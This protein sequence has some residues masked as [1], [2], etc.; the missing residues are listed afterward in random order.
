LTILRKK[1]KDRNFREILVLTRFL[2]NTELISLFKKEGVDD[3]SVGNLLNGLSANIEVEFREKGKNVFEFHEP[4]DKFYIILIGKVSVVK[5]IFKEQLMDAFSYYKYLIKLKADS[6][7]YLL[8]ATIAGN[9]QV[10]PVKVDELDMIEEVIFKFRLHRKLNSLLKQFRVIHIHS[11]YYDC[12]NDIADL[13]KFFADNRRNHRS[14]DLIIP[15]SVYD[16][17]DTVY[18][19]IEEYYD[20]FAEQNRRIFEAFSMLDVDF[21]EG[22]GQVDADKCKTVRLAEYEDLT[23][24]KEGQHFGDTALT[25]KGG[26]RN[27]TIKTVEECYFATLT[28]HIFTT[29]V[30]QERDRVTAK[31]ITFLNELTFFQSVKKIRFERYYSDFVMN[32]YP[33]GHVI[34]REGDEPKEI[35]IVKEGHVELKFK[36]SIIDLHNIITELKKL[37]PRFQPEKLLDERLIKL[38]EFHKKKNFVLFKLTYG[39]TLGLMEAIYKTGHF[40]EAIVS[41]DKAKFATLDS[42]KLTYM[43]ETEKYTNNDVRKFSFE[44]LAML[45]DRLSNI[46]NT[47]IKI[48]I[49]ENKSQSENFRSDDLF[50]HTPKVDKIEILHSRLEKRV[51]PDS[52][53][54]GHR[55]DMSSVFNLS[56]SLKRNYTFLT[57]MERLEG[58]IEAKIE[59]KLEKTAIKLHN[60]SQNNSLSNNGT[61]IVANKPQSDLENMIR[62]S[63]K[64]RPKTNIIRSKKKSVMV[65]ELMLRRLECNIA[66][67]QVYRCDGKDVDIGLVNRPPNRSHL[68]SPIRRTASAFPS[69][70]DFKSLNYLKRTGLSS[71]K[72]ERSS[73]S[74]LASAS[75]KSKYKPIFSF[76]QS[77]KI[78]KKLCIN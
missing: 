15:E 43:M 65:E 10:Y 13:N 69:V 24:L 64:V 19:L 36:K 9:T 71:A 1:P 49:K 66:Q 28:E 48:A 57:E 47:C 52:D 16:K 62:Y 32:T 58:K 51:L 3:S 31:D 70:S 72:L 53:K 45:I 7:N 50:L 11:Y 37:D 73:G 44:K 6:E 59:S 30:K 74:K 63:I 39:K 67:S 40:C 42:R 17:F 12:S 20:K 27:A 78:K 25:K 22:T 77:A 56:N 46:K 21:I 41:S 8:S 29:Y 23:V 60:Q 34:C 61:A 26:L 55:R 54:Q 75:K 14:Y 2:E 4:G 18:A 68:P 76:A 33:I 38:K 35:L 5:P